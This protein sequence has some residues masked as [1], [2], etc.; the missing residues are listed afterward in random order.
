MKAGA[1]FTSATLFQPTILLAL[2]LM[3]VILM[4][5]KKTVNMMTN[6]IR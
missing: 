5:K 1:K 2:A 6:T 3:G 4:I